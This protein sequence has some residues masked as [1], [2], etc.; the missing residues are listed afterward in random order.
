[1]SAATGKVLSQGV[2]AAVDAADRQ[3]L[4]KGAKKDPE[5]YVSSVDV[6]NI[7]IY[8]YSTA[9]SSPLPPLLSIRSLM[10]PLS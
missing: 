2:K 9:E 7:Y 10:S 8:I 5:L 6:I 1:M 4:K 3:V